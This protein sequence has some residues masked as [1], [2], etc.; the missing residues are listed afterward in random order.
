MSA[1]HVN[2]AD[3]WSGRYQGGTA[4]WDLGQETAVFQSCIEKGLFPVPPRSD[5]PVRHAPRVW[6]PGCGYGHDALLFARAGYYVTAMDFAPEPLTRLKDMAWEQHC[7]LDI[8]HADIFSALPH[9]AETFDMVVEYTCFCAI[10]PARREEYVRILSGVVKPNGCVV[11]LLFPTDTM[12]ESPPY[13][14]DISATLTLF[15]TYDLFCSYR[16]VPTESH[17]KRQGREELVFFVKR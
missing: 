4:Q 10:D 11:A 7:D 2:L 14:V 6:V 15:A 12:V 16:M 5:V 1:K 13:P 8:V 3:Y 17:P 9:Y